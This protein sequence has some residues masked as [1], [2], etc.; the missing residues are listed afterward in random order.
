VDKAACTE[1][2][3]AVGILKKILRKRR[4]WGDYIET[5]QDLKRAYR[6]VGEGLLVMA[7][8]KSSQEPTQVQYISPN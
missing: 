6:K 2:V 1:A 4:L 7:R 8:L 3:R 5:F